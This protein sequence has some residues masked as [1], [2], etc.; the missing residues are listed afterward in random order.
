MKLTDEGRRALLTILILLFLV[1]TIP[2]LAAGGLYL[3]MFAL[4]EGKS[5]YG[6]GFVFAIFLI[7][8]TLTVSTKKLTNLWRQQ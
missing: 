4:L 5:I 8:I 1:I 2:V 3:F 7:V 6:V